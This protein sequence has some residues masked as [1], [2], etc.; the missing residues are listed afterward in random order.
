MEMQSLDLPL[1]FFTVL[2]QTAIGMAM[3]AA[4]CLPATAGASPGNRLRTEWIMIVVLVSL[5]TAAAFLHIGKPLG[6]F[7]ILN[8]IGVSWLSREILL[9]GLFSGLAALNLLKLLPLAPKALQNIDRLLL[10][11]GTAVVGL[12]AVVATGIT[13]AWT[14]IDAIYNIVPLAFFLSTVF[15]LG[16]A[17][18]SWFVEGEPF[19]K[20]HGALV[21]ALVASLVLRIC[22][23]FIWLSGGTVVHNS[24]QHYL[25]SP[26][27]WL[28]ILA[29]L[30]ALYV[31]RGR[32]I[33][34]WLPILLVLVELMG[35]TA[36]F[37]LVE[38]S[39]SNIGNLY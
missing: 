22:L 4:L 27:H 21:M 7:R 8:N 28:H 36:I 25:Q 23:P 24:G 5:G 32:R 9:V 34:K 12:L 26:L 30:A 39:G 13:Y 17:F 14:G 1:V 3:F 33:P 18:A 31:I 29:F 6:V 11:R 35:R 2:T 16:A 19:L 20:V 38:T 37:A 15:V 10:M